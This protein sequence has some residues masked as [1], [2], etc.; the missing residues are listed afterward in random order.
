MVERAPEWLSGSGELPELVISS[1][2]RIARNLAGHRFSTRASDVEKEAVGLELQEVLRGLDAFEDS[3]ILDMSSLTELDRSF[4]VERHLATFNLLQDGE[5]SA[6]IVAP[7]EEKSAMLNEEDH[8]R[9]QVIRSGFSLEEATGD[10]LEISRAL[11]ERV[12]FAYKE[13]IGYLTACPSNVGTGLRLSVL[14]HLPGIVYSRDVESLLTELSKSNVVVRGFYGEGSNIQGNIFQVSS[15]ISLGVTE[16][17]ILKGFKQAVERILDHERGA[18]ERLLQD[19]REVV[20]DKI[21]RSLA[22]LERAR[23][24]SFKEA[25]EFSSAVRLGV[26]LGILLDYR[27]RTL[28]ELLLFAQP[29]HLQKLFSK[30]ME[31]RERDEK[32]ASYIKTKLKSE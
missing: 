7:K 20:E 1:R 30:K 3:A 9:L 23:L 26:G 28:N 5:A 27:I 2:A 32:R 22:L 14:L 25:A 21:Q 29:A 24:I 19:S 15:R 18:R 31:Q 17:E 12:T 8:L 10:V 16:E 4:V 11:G 13:S 6:V